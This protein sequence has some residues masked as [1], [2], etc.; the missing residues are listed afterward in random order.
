MHEELRATEGEAG[1]DDLCL[2]SRRIG[3]DLCKFLIWVT[4]G[5][6]PTLAVG[7]LDDH[8]ISPR[9]SMRR[10]EECGAFWA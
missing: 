2:A 4:P 8:N 1:N 5:I 6:A 9:R 10:G 7:R 3:H